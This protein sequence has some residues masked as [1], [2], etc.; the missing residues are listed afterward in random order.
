MQ[1]LIPVIAFLGLVLGIILKKTCK[2]EIKPGKPYFKLLKKLILVILVITLLYFNYTNNIYFY[3]LII[4]GLGLAWL[5]PN[6]YLYFGIAL[7][8]LNPLA[9]VLVFI[10]GLPQGTLKPELKKNLILFTLPF[11]LLFINF[12]FTGI[13]IGGLLTIL[14]KTIASPT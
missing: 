14:L 6:T 2:E 13:A 8:T 7:T 5:I 3:L 11:L 12:N 4:I 10:Y 1:Y 9:A